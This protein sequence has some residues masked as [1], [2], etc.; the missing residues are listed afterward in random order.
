MAEI[1]DN[2][3]TDMMNWLNT[4]LSGLSGAKTIPGDYVPVTG[5]KL[6]IV[7][8]HSIADETLND[9]D[10]VGALDSV[11]NADIED[12]FYK[13]GLDVTI[14][15]RQSAVKTSGH[16]WTHRVDFDVDEAHTPTLI[17]LVPYLIPLVSTALTLIFGYLIVSKITST[18]DKF[19]DNSGKG[20][21]LTMN[22]ILLVVAI[23]AVVWIIGK[24]FK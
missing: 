3:W 18:A 7:T 15:N 19:V 16:N 4:F 20:V 11:S 13:Q 1:D 23:L 17:L 6:G 10:M 24:A 8:K 5:D 22:M 12:E 14:T 9:D 21:G 2:F